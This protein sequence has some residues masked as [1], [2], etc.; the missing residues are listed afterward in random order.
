MR[1]LMQGIR[2]APLWRHWPCCL[3]YA[4]TEWL[5][6]CWPVG[7]PIMQ[8]FSL[9]AIALTI[10]L[11]VSKSM[12]QAR[13]YCA[14]LLYRHG[15]RQAI[16]LAPRSRPCTRT[17]L[18]YSMWSSSIGVGVISA[19]SFA[20]GRVFS[21]FSYEHATPMKNSGRRRQYEEQPTD[22]I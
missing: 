7:F 19:G 12:T 5:T 4:L 15:T 21:A 6:S 18:Q 22:E 3:L 17:C 16:R 8:S 2:H 10:S 9:S 11:A 20:S 14:M 1:R 13:G